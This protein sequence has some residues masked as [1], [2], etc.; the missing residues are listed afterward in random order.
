MAE[1]ALVQVTSQSSSVRNVMRSDGMGGIPDPGEIH[2]E[3]GSG[4]TER[5][6]GGEA[7]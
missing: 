3:R 1:G 4:N 6:R 5:G 7:S 2:S